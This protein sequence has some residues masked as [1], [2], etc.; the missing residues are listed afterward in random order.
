MPEEQDRMS[1][2]PDAILHQIL[3][4][5]PTKHS[6]QT[7]I[8]SKRW[9]H[10]WK[11]TPA[12][13]IPYHDITPS[14]RAFLHNTL[15]Q[16]QALK[17]HNFTFH[18]SVGIAWYPDL[19]VH[20]QN[21]IEFAISRQVQTLSLLAD[22]VAA[23]I[24]PQDYYVL[25]SMFYSHENVRSLQQALLSNC[26]VLESLTI[27][28]CHRLHN[29]KASW[30]QRMKLKHLVLRCRGDDG[31]TV[32]IDVS[33]LSTLKVH[34]DLMKISFT[35]LPSMVEATVFRCIYSPYT[36]EFCIRTWLRNL[37]NVN[38][39]GVD[40]WFPQ[41]HTSFCCWFGKFLAREHK[42]NSNGW[43][44]F[45][46]LKVFSWFGPLAKESDLIALIAFLG[47]CPLLEK[48]EIDFRSS[49]WVEAGKDRPAF[50]LER[51]FI[52]LENG[53]EELTV[54]FL[55]NVKNIMVHHYFGYKSEV[56]FIKHL[57][58]KAVVLETL[59]L[60]YHRLELNPEF[61]G[62]GRSS[63]SRA[64]ELV[65]EEIFNLPRASSLVHILFHDTYHKF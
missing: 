8:L 23:F 7:S 51:P 26:P 15:T 34:G 33:S 22:L 11:F 53:D 29:F 3:S 62:Y 10:L 61:Y 41:S 47:H 25:P 36:Q 49:Y 4:F 18:F 2:L 57:L 44:I 32:E 40:S 19:G 60:T 20:V 1:A 14:E 55:H 6:I 27:E 65:R 46:N 31:L 37:A 43:M 64:K 24:D 28:G 59:S 42:V 58:Q 5:L 52:E 54:G 56:E 9:I 30:C 35:S 50:A 39:L 13:D 12:I 16:H 38:K 17:I 48:I 63:H 45:E 21:C